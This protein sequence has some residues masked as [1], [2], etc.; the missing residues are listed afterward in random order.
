MSG[1]EKRRMM[2]YAHFFREVF[3]KFMGNSSLIVLEYHLSKKLSGADPFELLLTEPRAFYDALVSIFGPEGSFL[4]LKLLFKQIV[5]GYRLTGWSAD[6]FVKSII[7]GGENAR[8]SLLKLLEEIPLT[9][10]T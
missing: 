4:L 5:D 10:N 6:E 8:K 3:K 7:S 2:V 9:E 1:G